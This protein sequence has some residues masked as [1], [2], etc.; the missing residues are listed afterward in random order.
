M[1]PEVVLA[2]AARGG[3]A[4]GRAVLGRHWVHGA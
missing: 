3:M 4:N 1:S 2:R